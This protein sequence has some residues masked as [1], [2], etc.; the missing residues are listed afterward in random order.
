MSENF[1]ENNNNQLNNGSSGDFSQEGTEDLL[2][3]IGNQ[4]NNIHD[5]RQVSSSNN[6]SEGYIPAIF[7]YLPPLIHEMFKKVSDFQ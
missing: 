6:E 2:K 7:E 4:I 1:N 5:E 3:K